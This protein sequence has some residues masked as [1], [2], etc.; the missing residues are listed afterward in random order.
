MPFAPTAHQQRSLPFLHNRRS[1]HLF[2]LMHPSQAGHGFPD[3]HTCSTQPNSLH[4]SLPAAP[5]YGF[6]TARGLAIR[7]IHPRDTHTQLP[8]NTFYGSISGEQ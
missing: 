6:A 5:Q 3:S 4:R 7:P 1:A 2:S 8:T